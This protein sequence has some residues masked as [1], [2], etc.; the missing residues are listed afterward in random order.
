MRKT[1]RQAPARW[2]QALD[3]PLWL[4][5]M[6]LVD[7][8]GASWPSP[9]PRGWPPGWMALDRRRHNHWGM[10]MPVVVVPVEAPGAFGAVMGLL[11]RSLVGAMVR[12]GLLAAEV[13]GWRRRARG[14]GWSVEVAELVAADWPAGD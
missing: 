4:S 12:A 3:D 7:A 9:L 13:H 6:L 10:R 8:Y 11:E 1:K 5:R 14:R 2:R